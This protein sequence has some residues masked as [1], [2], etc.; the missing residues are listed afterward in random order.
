M[1]FFLAQVLIFAGNFAPR[2]WAFCQGQLLAI[3]SNTALFSLL[4][5]IY[6]GDGRTTFGLPDLRGRTPIGVGN[7]PGL[8]SYR[9]GQKGGA[10][11]TTLTTANM[12]SHNHAFMANSSVGTVSVPAANSIIAATTDSRTAGTNLYNMAD[13]NVIMKSSSI[14]HAGGSQSFNNMQPYLAMNYVIC[15]Q[16]LFPSRN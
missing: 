9:E 3:N 1:E 2:S 8:P 12:P 4:G 14:S 10:S 13:P 6:G 5:T 7:G 15:L 16:G 11:T